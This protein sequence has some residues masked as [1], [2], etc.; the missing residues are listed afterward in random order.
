LSQPRR[1]SRDLFYVEADSEPGQSNIQRKYQTMNR[2]ILVL[3]GLASL[4]A[5]A[6]A[7]GDAAK[8]AKAFKKCQ[9]CHSAED[10]TN[11]VGPSLKGV[12]GRAVATADGYNYSEAMKAFGAA[13]A[14]WDVANL[15]AYMENPKTFIAGN[16]MTF[17]GIKKEDERADIIAFLKT[18]M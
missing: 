15:N 16:K 12:V 1:K 6:H 13:G 9:A 10:A 5:P 17:A 4:A 2:F 18:K 14:V 8:G 11:K 3:A 7:D